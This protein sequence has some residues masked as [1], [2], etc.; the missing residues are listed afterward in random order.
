MSHG[1]LSTRNTGD[2]TQ[3]TPSK[4]PGSETLLAG[5]RSVL[6]SYYG[7]CE[8]TV[9]DREPNDYSSGCPSEI[10]TCVPAG[11]NELRLLCKYGTP[12]GQSRGDIDYEAKVYRHVVEHCRLPAPKFYGSH[13]DPD[14]RTWLILE[15]LNSGVLLNEALDPDAMCLAAGW[16][17]RFH[18][19]AQV[20][21]GDQEAAFLKTYDARYYLD[22]ARRTLEFCGE[23]NQ[24]FD[25]LRVLC[26]EFEGFAHTFAEKRITITHGDFY[27]H[28]L[29]WKG[30]NIYPLDWELAGIKLG[31][32]DLACLTDGWEGETARR[33]ELEYQRA[34]WPEGAPEDFERTLGAG[35]LCLYFYNLGTEP[36]WASDSHGLWYSR[37]L[38]AVGEQMGLIKSGSAGLSIRSAAL[39]THG[40]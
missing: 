10:V 11:G 28:N 37:Q 1:N 32:W 12:G 15:Y 36:N 26:G 25:W 29:L 3:A 20:L 38:R 7:R 6:N 14:G 16:L 34:R 33:C 22:L 21:L 17:G 35:R 8:L 31:E 30:S 39:Q 2:S 9:L 5:L 19:A 40:L 13:V 18:A 23:S 24:S 4:F 27:L